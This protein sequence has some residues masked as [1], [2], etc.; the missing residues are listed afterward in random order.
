MVY[1][2]KLLP[3]AAEDLDNALDWYK[4]QGG[5]QLQKRFFNAYQ[6]VRKRMVKFPEASSPFFDIY[7]K[8][9]LKKFPFKVIYRI[10]KDA[11]IVV[12]VAH[13]RRSVDYWKD[14]S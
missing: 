12:A 10:E 1:S 2:Y 6:K 8:T 9:R 7:R 4:I 3:E 11:I 13:D 14:R 5:I